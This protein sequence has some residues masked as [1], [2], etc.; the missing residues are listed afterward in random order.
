MSQPLCRAHF[1]QEQGRIPNTYPVC[2][3]LYAHKPPCGDICV[4]PSGPSDSTTSHC[5]PLCSPG[6]YQQLQVPAPQHSHVLLLAQLGIAHGHHV[7]LVLQPQKLHTVGVPL[8]PQ[9]LATLLHL[10]ELFQLLLQ[11]D[12]LLLQRLVFHLEL[13]LLQQVLFPLSS[14]LLH[15]HHQELS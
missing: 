7:V 5:P 15:L 6:S 11:P 14:H 9:P 1:H 10:Q 3:L 8:F 13:V 2:Q 12:L 4:H